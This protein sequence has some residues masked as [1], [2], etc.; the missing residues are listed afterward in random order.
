LELAEI[1][2]DDVIDTM[3]AQLNEIGLFTFD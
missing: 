3:L 1:I 2:N